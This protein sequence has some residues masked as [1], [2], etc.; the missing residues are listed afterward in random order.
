MDGI[1]VGYWEDEKIRKKS[2]DP[3]EGDHLGSRGLDER[4]M[5]L[6]SDHALITFQH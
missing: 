4:M 2:G 5:Q 1:Y 3:Q 6:A